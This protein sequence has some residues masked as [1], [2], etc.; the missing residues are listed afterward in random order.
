[1]V[2]MKA[3]LRSNNTL[4]SSTRAAIKSQTEREHFATRNKMEIKICELT[5]SSML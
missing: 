5:K 4:N 3:L 2:I 1:M